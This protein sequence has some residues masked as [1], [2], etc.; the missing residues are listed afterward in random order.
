MPVDASIY[1]QLTPQRPV[2][3][4]L[5][6]YGRAMQIKNLMG[7]GELQGL[8]IGEARRGIEEQQR[9]R[10][11]FGTTSNPTASQVM[12][13]SPTSGMN[14]QKYLLDREKSQAAIDKDR[15][16][17]TSRNIKTMR[18]LIAQASSDADMP[19]LKE[20]ALKLFGPEL[21]TKIGVPDRFDP[22]WQR[23]KI[24]SADDLL[25]RINPEGKV[26][27]QGGTTG[28]VNPYTGVPIGPRLPK[29]LSPADEIAA[30]RA[31]T[32][33][34][35]A[36]Y[37]G[38]PLPPSSIPGDVVPAAAPAPAATAPSPQAAP[39][40]PAP[41]AAAAP[42]DTAGMTPKARDEL[43]AKR[44]A[45]KPQE[46]QSAITL[47]QTLDNVINMGVK[48]YNHK[49]LGAVTGRILGKEGGYAREATQAASQDAADAQ[50]LIDTLKSQ[51]GVQ[52]LQAMRA[53]SKSGGAVGQ[54]SEKE[55]PILQNQL[56]AL[57][58]TQGT[59]A[60]KEN[61][62]AVL[63]TLQRMREN[64]VLAYKRVYGDPGLPPAP[65]IPQT[66]STTSGKIKFLGFE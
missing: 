46:T 32:A 64:E 7:A 53:A 48:L 66:P 31:R 45:A 14:Y 24:M 61:L 25:K 23:T 9:L 40:V 42:D 15:A 2:E 1:S 16:E 5:D 26:V 57:Q 12:A 6:Q 63:E 11:L 65:K 10:D 54:V 59:P 17:S 56:G 36:A 51:I 58:Q 34:A 4:P 29:T 55:W 28:L 49:G 44:I 21:A 37:G 39:T 35:E 18:D 33:R 22:N 52:T 27:D 30:D 3:G 8:Q 43:R 19:V 20:M 41:T 13:I 38:V 60:F 62:R 50:A 47:T